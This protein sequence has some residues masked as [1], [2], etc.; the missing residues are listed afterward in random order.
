MREAYYYPNELRVYKMRT[1]KLNTPVLK[2]NRGQGTQAAITPVRFNDYAQMFVDVVQDM[3]CTELADEIV[4][5][6]CEVRDHAFNDVTLT[7]MDDWWYS[8]ARFKL[9]LMQTAKQHLLES[10][11]YY[12]DLD[13]DAKKA[14]HACAR[15]L[16]RIH[17]THN[18]IM[19]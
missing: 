9:A 3:C 10:E 16:Q 7:P 13:E 8:T 1:P 18:V 6:L 12:E 4:A 5:D 19:K 14:C 2:E 17:N 15:E 11:M